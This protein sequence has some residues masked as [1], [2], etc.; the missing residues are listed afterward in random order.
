LHA[1]GGMS[2]TGRVA[3]AR[4]E[5]QLGGQLE[6]DAGN[7]IAHVSGQ[8]DLASIKPFLTTNAANGFSILTT[9]VPLVLALDAA[10]NLHALAELTATGR[11]ALANFAVREQTVDAVAGRVA[12]ADRVL[13]FIQ[14]ELRRENGAQAATADEV[15]LDFKTM[16][17]SFTNGFSTLA[18]TAL[19]RAIGPMTAHWVEP[20]QFLQPPVARV[21]GHLPLRNVASPH[22]TAGTDLRFDI[23]QYVPFQWLKLHST[24]LMG[25]IRW[26]GPELVLTNITG[27]LYGGIG[28]G[29]AYF[30]FSVPHPGADYN[31]TLSVTNVDLH[32]FAQ[33]MLSPTNHLE[34]TLAGLLV[35]TRANT[36]DLRSW[37]GYG[38]AHL[39]DGLLWDIPIF[40]IISPVLNTF[41]AGLGNSRATEATARYL[42]TNGI[43]SSDSLE[44]RSTLMRL[45]YT[46][47]V[48]MLQNV[49]A[50]VT[51]RLLRDIPVVGPLIGLATWPLGK[52]FECRVTGKLGDPEVTPIY[53]PFSRL[54]LAPLHPIRSLEELFSPPNSTNAPPK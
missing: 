51:A 43:I 33:G 34:G 22:D 26:L 16:V 38:T 17:L 7:F 12:F 11:V 19:T 21:N 20:Y 23:L 6:K 14:P 46:G 36:E 15:A 35:V 47:T 48:D 42:I 4:T 10:G 30:D 49:N 45:G 27:D 5:L 32:R 54:L 25:T 52:A 44:I 31:F 39:H 8:F 40:G 18:P 3:Q 37:D 13:H 53:I 9:T 2:V 28:T 41:S 29:A 1:V 24:G 50:H